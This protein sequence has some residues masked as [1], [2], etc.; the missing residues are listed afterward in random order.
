M[1][2]KALKIMH[3]HALSGI[4]PLYLFPILLYSKYV[5]ICQ[6][7]LPIDYKWTRENYNN[8]NRNYH[9]KIPCATMLG[10]YNPPLSIYSLFDH[11]VQL[12]ETLLLYQTVGN[13]YRG[14][15][16]LTACSCMSLC[17]YETITYIIGGIPSATNNLHQLVVVGRK[18][19]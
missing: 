1:V 13:T 4:K 16:P 7:K 6:K 9:G 3:E 14:S 2:S 17:S 11:L 15:L 19:C 12:R 18:L 10:L 8:P 5:S